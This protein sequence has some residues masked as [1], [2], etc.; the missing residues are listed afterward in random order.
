MI[1]GKWYHI[2][3]NLHRFCPY[4]LL[5]SMSMIEHGLLSKNMAVYNSI[6][7]PAMFMKSSPVALY[8]SIYRFPMWCLC[9]LNA[10]SRWAA[11]SNSTRA[12]PFR[13]PWLLK[14]KATP[15]LKCIKCD[16]QSFVLFRLVAKSQIILSDVR[17]IL[18]K[19]F[20]TRKK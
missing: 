9:L 15:P 20:C 6:L 8:T 18:F 2:I 16:D 5:F 3:E 10:I 13:R 11:F 17:E 7:P 12:S 4:N 19:K 14:H 1:Y